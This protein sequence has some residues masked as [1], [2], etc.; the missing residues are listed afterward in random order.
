MNTDILDDILGENLD[1]AQQCKNVPT[2]IVD[3]SYL[4][5][6]S[7]FSAW[8]TFRD[9]YSDLCPVDKDP[10]FD[11]GDHPE[12][13]AIFK[14]RFYSSVLTAP[15][16]YHPFIEERNII[17]ATDCPKKNIW[18]IE[19]YPEYKQER[20]DA[21]KE[22]KP[23]AFKR[24]FSF[25]YNTILPEWEDL[26]SI[27]V[28]APCSEGDDVIATLVK[29][30]IAKT[31]IVMAS[32]RDIL[33]LSSPTCTMINVKGDHITYSNELDIPEEELEERN[34]TGKHYILIK[35]MMGDRSDGITQIH[36]RC[37]KKTAIKYFFDP[38]LLNAKRASDPGI[39][40]IIKN[41]ILIMDFDY[42]P[43]EIDSAIMTKYKEQ[44]NC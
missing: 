6:H 12:F 2:L 10:D 15:M 34:F 5:Y 35:A 26:G 40:P 31:F 42:I 21:K 20:R 39:D 24:T 29:N 14:Q 7:M 30:K 3:T 17:F 13:L 16:K 1:Q 36:K 33:Q 22:D 25:L 11:P 4:A 9:Q 41:N 38:D 28:G 18:R 43:D 19:H 23:F 8:N 27:V 44:I 32:D 37:G